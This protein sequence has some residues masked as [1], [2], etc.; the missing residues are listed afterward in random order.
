[1]SSF[2]KKISKTKWIIKF[3]YKYIYSCDKNTNIYF[4]FIIKTND[5]YSI[6]ISNN[7]EYNQ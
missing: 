4:L 6:K 5:I 7:I 1:M 2:Y 3:E